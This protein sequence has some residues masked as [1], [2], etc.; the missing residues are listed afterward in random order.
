[1]SKASQIR[2]KAQELLQKGQVEKAVQEYRRLISIE[3]KNPNLYNELGDIYLRASDRDQAVQSYEKAA[4]IYERVALYNN[5]VAVCKKIL[6]VNPERIETILKLAE[7]RA[8]QKLEGEAG[9]FFAQYVEGV[10]AGPSSHLQRSQRDVERMLELMPASETILAKAAE[11]FVQLGM[12][13]RTAE[14]F[15]K[16]AGIADGEG[17]AN[18]SAKYRRKIEE[19]KT[20]LSDEEASQIEEIGASPGGADAPPAAEAET[21]PAAEAD[22]PPRPADVPGAAA[23]RTAA[24]EAGREDASQEYAVS[25]EAAAPASGEETEA[26]PE[27][28]NDAGTG[29]VSGTRAADAAHVREA[30]EE[31]EMVAAMSQGRG[32]FDLGVERRKEPVAPPRMERAEPP[33]AP[34]WTEPPPAP[35][36][37]ERPPESPRTEPPPAPPRVEPTESSELVEEITSDVE[38]DDLRSH[39]DLGMAYLEMGLYTESIRDFQ[40]ASRCED[41]QLSSMEMIGYCFLK[42][43]QARLAVKQL[44]R[45]LDIASATGAD[46]LGIHYNL[47]L[48]YE[49]VGEQAR[50][51]EHFEE[52]YI[53]DMSFRDVAEKMKKLSAVS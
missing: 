9:S 53:I 43:G 36:R 34:P 51:R 49:M 22:A 11:V 4:V 41:L 3:S 8:K 32:A 21:P 2:Q 14:L 31:A 13:L 40:I 33:P 35:P 37:M 38:K 20:G 15:S 5:A 26:E 47:G 18:K 23:A 7:L 52:V 12:K 17:D 27:E 1:M 16:L 39:Y 25:P 48:A 46:S 19:L 50:A 44:Q 6:R 24:G 45:A 10:L 42:S 30:V 29:A 28:T